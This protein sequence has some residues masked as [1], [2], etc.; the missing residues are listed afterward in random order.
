[1]EVINSEREIMSP[2]SYILQL[3]ENETAKQIE[4]SGEQGVI[5]KREN[6]EGV[7]DYTLRLRVGGYPTEINIKYYG[8]KKSYSEK[9]LIKIGEAL[10]RKIK[11]IEVNKY[12]KTFLDNSNNISEEELK[13]IE[14]VSFLSSDQEEFFRGVKEKFNVDYELMNI[15][16]R[17]EFKDGGYFSLSTNG[18]KDLVLNYAEGSTSLIINMESYGDSV[19]G[20]DFGYMLGEVINIDKI[21]G[22]EVMGNK[23]KIYKDGR[24]RRAI[25][26]GMKE[27]GVSI[28]IENMGSSD[29]VLTKV[30]LQNI[31]R[32][33]MEKVYNNITKV[34]QDHSTVK[35]N[36]MKSMSEFIESASSRNNIKIPMYIPNTFNFDG[37]RYEGK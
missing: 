4:L 19:G 36:Y 15:P 10:I 21:D 37:A 35:G 17:Y 7:A 34:E 12:I 24:V 5:I 32:E 30:E 18:R 9:E 6:V 22:Y 2:N 13:A 28:C 31:L 14:K 8:N 3:H 1:M 16:G 29:K 11:A 26:L 27:Y 20:H 33:L 25:S 23:D